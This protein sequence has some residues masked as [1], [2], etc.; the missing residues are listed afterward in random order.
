MKLHWITG[1]K[2]PVAVESERQT[3]ADDELYVQFVT[4]ITFIILIVTTDV[5][6]LQM[7]D[8]NQFNLFK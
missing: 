5:I 8:L 3:F 7:H 2:P 6:L 4:T 1:Q